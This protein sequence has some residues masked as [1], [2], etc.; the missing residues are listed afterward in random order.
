MTVVRLSADTRDVDAML[1]RA[2][3][4]LDMRNAQR[5]LVDFYTTRER[6]QFSRQ[7]WRRLS[8]RYAAAK[9]RQFPGRGILQRTDALFEGLT[10]PEVVEFSQD[11]GV[12]GIRTGQGRSPLFYA[13]FAQQGRGEPKRVVMPPLK[14]EERELVVDIIRVHVLRP[15]LRRARS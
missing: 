14:T 15:V 1:D 3:A 8:R 12:V 9:A 7:P 4:P 10:T 11:I 5:A 2:G 13:Q 6:E